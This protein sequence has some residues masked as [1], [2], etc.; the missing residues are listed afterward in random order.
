MVTY[1]YFYIKYLICHSK[2]YAKYFQF[3]Q[4]SP[5]G[6]KYLFFF[7]LFFFIIYLPKFRNSKKRIAKKL[8][9]DPM[10]ELLIL[11]EHREKHL[12]KE[13]IVCCWLLK[14]CQGT[15]VLLGSLPCPQEGAGR[16]LLIYTNFILL[17]V[18][19]PKHVFSREINSAGPLRVF[20]YPFPALQP[21]VSVF[22]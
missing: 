17:A 3:P 18:L 4:E 7:F 16:R 20:L 12:G 8:Q 9:R 1:E 19:D 22:P 10:F 21:R 15:C 11:S 6:K 2:T 13:S 14:Y 5:R